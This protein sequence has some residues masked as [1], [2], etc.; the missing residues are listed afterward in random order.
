MLRPSQNWVAEQLLRSLGAA[1]GGRGSWAAG[2]A[3]E[4]RYLVDV[5]GIDSLADP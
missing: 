4:R 2:I 5:V 1:D 3:A